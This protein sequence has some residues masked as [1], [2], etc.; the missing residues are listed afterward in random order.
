MAP[1]QCGSPSAK[2]A[3]LG[4]RELAARLAIEYL[5][6]EPGSHVELPGLGLKDM[7]VTIPPSAG[8]PR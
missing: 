5:G 7:T 4:L 2:C 8:G 3:W 1:A 6:A